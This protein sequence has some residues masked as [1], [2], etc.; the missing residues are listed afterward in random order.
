MS[1]RARSR[2]E[3]YASCSFLTL[4][5]GL[6]LGGQALAAEATTASPA[7]EKEVDAVVVTTAKNQ[8][9]LVAPVSSNLAAPEPQAVITRKFIE[10]S[11]PRVGD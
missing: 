2:A 11:A 7:A 4:A 9:A 1:N 10:E 3:A 8:A 5:L 6:A